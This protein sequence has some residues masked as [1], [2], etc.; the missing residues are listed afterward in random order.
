MAI[1]HPSAYRTA[2]ATEI[3]NLIDAGSGAGLLKVYDLSSNLLATLTF[4]YPCGTVTAEV[5]TFSAIAADM[6]PALTGTAATFTITDSANNIVFSGACGLNGGAG[7]DLNFDTLSII[8]ETPFYC[9]NTNTYTAL[10]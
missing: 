2:K 9:L 10:P 1:T 5:L 3:K 4:S 8:A 6:S 7:G